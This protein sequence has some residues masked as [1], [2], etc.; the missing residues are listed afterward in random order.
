M[1]GQEVFERKDNR[2]SIQQR[3]AELLLTHRQCLVLELQQRELCPCPAII[4]NARHKDL[5]DTENPLSLR[6]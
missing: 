1:D 3:F 5:G 2:V 6:E 4:V